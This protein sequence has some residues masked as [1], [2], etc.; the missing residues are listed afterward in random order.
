[1]GVPLLHGEIVEAAQD[2]PDHE[3]L[4]SDITLTI[5]SLMS[6]KTQRRDGSM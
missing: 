2:R 6:K 4:Q 1:M 3:R 5:S